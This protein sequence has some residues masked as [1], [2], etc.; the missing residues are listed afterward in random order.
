MPARSCSSSAEDSTLTAALRR[1]SPAAAAP[2]GTI[3]KDALGAARVL[4]K[5]S[6]K[7]SLQGPTKSARMRRRV[8]GVAGRSRRCF[9]CSRALQGL[10][11]RI[12]EVV[13]ACFRESGARLASSLLGD[14]VVNQSIDDLGSE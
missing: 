5:M 8:F 13:S 1:F 6:L 7:S 10:I 11:P 12:I 4:S 2:R 3:A 14:A 9:G